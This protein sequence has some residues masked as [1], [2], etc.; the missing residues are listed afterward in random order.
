MSFTD[1]LR[2]NNLEAT[3]NLDWAGPRASSESLVWLP[4]CLPIFLPVR[5]PKLIAGHA[6]LP[7]DILAV[8]LVRN[9]YKDFDMGI[10][11]EDG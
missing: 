8:V 7:R 1:C 9:F 10:V 2:S 3:G 4:G 5:P 11:Q 6:H